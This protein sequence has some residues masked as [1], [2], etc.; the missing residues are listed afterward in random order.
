MKKKV[1]DLIKHKGQFLDS[2]GYESQ[3]NL[4]KLI[5][6]I[7]KVCS[8]KDFLKDMS[9]DNGYSFNEWSE[10]ILTQKMIESFE[11]EFN[12]IYGKEVK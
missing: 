4:A 2:Y 10:I 7:L 6:K 9:E 3:K 11:E 12:Y 1:Q 5:K 8:V